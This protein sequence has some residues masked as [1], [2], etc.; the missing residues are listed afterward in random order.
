MTDKAV[1]K[2]TENLIKRL[3]YI[4]NPR[5]KKGEAM[6]IDYY[7]S[8][9]WWI[10]NYYRFATHI[11]LDCNKIQRQISTL[12]K[13]RLKGRLKRTGSLLGKYIQKQYGKSK[14]MHFINRMPICHIGYIKIKNAMNRRKTVCKYTARRQSRNLQ[15]SEARY[16][17][18]A[19]TDEVKKPW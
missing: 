7:N 11:S 5:N 1:K 4:Q 13:N 9:V 18:S 8:T 10:H 16:T 19:G 12:M 17:G 15:K 3:K 14:Q 6:A 2:E